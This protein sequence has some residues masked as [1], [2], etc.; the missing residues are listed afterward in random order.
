[1]LHFTDRKENLSLNIS[2]FD[3]VK[4]NGAVIITEM[5]KNIYNLE[6]SLYVAIDGFSKLS[7]GFLD[8]FTWQA[9]F[10]IIQELIVNTEMYLLNSFVISMIN[11]SNYATLVTQN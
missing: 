7:E 2:D 8:M 4:E 9:R 6:A 1:M 3:R 10:T 11:L 5:L